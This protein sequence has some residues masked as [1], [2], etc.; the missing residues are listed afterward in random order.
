MTRSCA[1]CFK[2]INHDPEAVVQCKK[3]CNR[4][5]CSNDCLNIDCNAFDHETYCGRSGENSVDFEIRSATGKGL[6]IF[7]KRAFTRGEIVLIDRCAM[8]SPLDI[9]ESSVLR[10][11]TELTPRGGTLQEIYSIN[12]FRDGLF[13][14]MSRINNECVANCVI[15]VPYHLDLM[16]CLASRDISS[17]DE[18]TISYLPLEVNCREIDEAFYCRETAFRDHWGFVCDCRICTDEMYSDFVEDMR[19]IL[20]RMVNFWNSP[21]VTFIDEFV[22]D[23]YRLIRLLDQLNVCL[24]HHMTI[25]QSMFTISLGT[26]STLRQASKFLNLS[27]RYQYLFNGQR[28]TLSSSLSYERNLKEIRDHKDYLW[29]ERGPQHSRFNKE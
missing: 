25:Y 9:P 22:R 18:I 13:V 26:T 4:I 10:A 7:A 12:S 21:V 11:V 16:E 28:L 17:G 20:V 14:L 19:T 29:G 1:H 2:F 6:G 5:Y 27:K 3:C 24:R 8:S 15:R 23:G